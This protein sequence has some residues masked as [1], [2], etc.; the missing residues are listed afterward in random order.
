M[1]EGDGLKAK[2]F[3]HC[4]MAVVAVVALATTP[5]T[6]SNPTDAD[7]FGVGPYRPCEEKVRMSLSEAVN[8]LNELDGRIRPVPLE[9]LAFFAREELHVFDAHDPRR[10]GAFFGDPYCPL[11][12]L[13]NRM[14]KLAGE[15]QRFAGVQQGTLSA[16]EELRHTSR[17]L[18]DFASCPRR[19][20]FEPPGRLNFEPGWRPV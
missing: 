4:V 19:R 9:K 6:I 5:P 14:R 16:N 15:V 17:L 20:N 2:T 3:R 7:P 1:P 18:V 11:W 8:S 13:H 10:M 12:T